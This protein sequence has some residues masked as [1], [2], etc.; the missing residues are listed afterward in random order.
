M[1]RSWGVI[2]TPRSVGEFFAYIG[3]L[4]VFP[5]YEKTFGQAGSV[6]HREQVSTEGGPVGTTP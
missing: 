6:A 3:N 2:A 4:S 1:A 5:G